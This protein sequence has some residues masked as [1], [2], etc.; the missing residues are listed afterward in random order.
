M[1]IL[2]VLYNIYN[3]KNDKI[4]RV[5][6]IYSIYSVSYKN[7]VLAFNLRVYDVLCINAR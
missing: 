4:C 5:Y 3:K 2:L 6:S 7:L 1:I